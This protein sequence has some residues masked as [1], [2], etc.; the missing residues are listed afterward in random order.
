MSRA[1][2]ASPVAAMFE[3]TCGAD[4]AERTLHEPRCRAPVLPLR[5]IRRFNA[6]TETFSYRWRRAVL[7]DPVGGVALGHADD[8]PRCVAHLAPV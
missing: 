5:R 1:Q 3:A 7:I 4:Q 8:C 6:R 2:R